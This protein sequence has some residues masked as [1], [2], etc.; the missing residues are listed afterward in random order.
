M[1]ILVLKDS[2]TITSQEDL[3]HN[4]TADSLRC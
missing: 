4:F 2:K 1:L 3:F